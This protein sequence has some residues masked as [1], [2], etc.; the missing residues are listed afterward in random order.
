MI[1]CIYEPTGEPNAYRC[2]N[3]G[4]ERASKHPPHLLHR[5]CTGPG[6]LTLRPAGPVKLGPGHFL[7]QMLEA[8]GIKQGGCS[9]KAMAA[10]M[11]A[12]G[13]AGCLE[14]MAEILDH[15]EQQAWKRLE[16]FTR[17]DVELVVLL[18]IGA[19]EGEATA[20]ALPADPRP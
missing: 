11:D 2:R 16:P 20:S 19:A 10:K 7:K 15:L 12:W 3:C 8:S 18:A 13:P 1:D 5:N 6:S 14:H 4:H 9:C 17:S